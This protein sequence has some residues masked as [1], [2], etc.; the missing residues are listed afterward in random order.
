M[1]HYPDVFTRL[2]YGIWENLSK[3]TLIQAGNASR[4]SAALCAARGYRTKIRRK[5]ATPEGPYKLQV[6]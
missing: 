3:S 1:I 4:V 5:V 2:L 6:V